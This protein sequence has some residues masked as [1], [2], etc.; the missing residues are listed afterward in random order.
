MFVLDDHGDGRRGPGG[1]GLVVQRGA[2]GR[3]VGDPGR[4]LADAQLLDDNN[5]Y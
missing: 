3:Q 2:G 1:V 4:Y 5:S